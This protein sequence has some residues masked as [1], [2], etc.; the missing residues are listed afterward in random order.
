M[1][2]FNLLSNQITIAGFW[3]MLLSS[4]ALWVTSILTIGVILVNGWTDAPNAIATCVAT[5]AMHPKAAILMAAIFNFFGVFI[6]TLVSPKVTETIY[7]MVNFGDNSQDALV[8]LCAAMV[9]IVTWAILAW[10][11]GIPTSES[12]ALIAGLTGSAIAINGSFKGVNGSEWLNVLYGIVVSLVLGFGLSYLITKLLQRL[13]AKKDYRK[14]NRFFGKGQIVAAAGTAFMHGAQDGQKFM[15][16]FILGMALSQGN[17]HTTMM[18]P[19]WWLMVLCS[20]V[21]CLGTSIGGMKIIKSVGLDMVKLEAYQGFSADLSA[22]AAL[23]ICSITGMPVST[24]HAKTISIMGA[25]AAKRVKS[26]NWNVAKEMVYTWILTFP[27]CGI[28]GFLMTKLFLAI[29]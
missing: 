28:I 22:S 17:A 8:A 11:F 3:Q 16:I 1:A 18:Q 15:S 5:R 10:K 12:H 4:P 24:T 7:K 13:C 21:M 20:A 9:A 27:G 19:P 25:G 26:V 29:F 2:V 23:L 14:A 6:M